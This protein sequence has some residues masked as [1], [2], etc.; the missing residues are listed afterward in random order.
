[1]AQEKP[2]GT[3]LLVRLQSVA[4]AIAAWSIG[5]V[6]ALFV[7]GIALRYLFNRPQSWIDEAVTLLAVWSTFWTAAVV[8]K[9]PEHIAFDI[10]Y[11][12][13]SPAMKRVFLLVGLVVFSAIM[14][15]AMPGMIDYTLFLWRERT[16]SMQLRLDFVYSIFPFFF[17]VILLRLMVSI[18]RLLTTGWRAELT[19]WGGGGDSEEKSESRP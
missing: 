18:G 8:L 14:L 12:H 2:V 5:L 10:V 13:V 19:R 17:A 7:A 3:A 6:F 16:D 11:S 15:A 1:M 9:W 4:R